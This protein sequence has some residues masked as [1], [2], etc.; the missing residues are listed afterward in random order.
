MRRLVLESYRKYCECYFRL[1]KFY[2]KFRGVLDRKDYEER[3]END[4][5]INEYNIR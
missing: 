1:K 5:R 2:R 4:E 3:I